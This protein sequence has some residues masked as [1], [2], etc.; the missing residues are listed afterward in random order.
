M[1]DNLQLA[2]EM[3]FQ[4]SDQ[5]SSDH[6][7]AK[8]FLLLADIYITKENNFQAKAT[9]ESIIEHHDGEDLVN[10]ARKKWEEIIEDEIAEKQVLE[11]QS[12][13][14]IL[15]YEVDYEIEFDVDTTPVIDK[16]YEVQIS[17]SLNI[18]MDSLEMIK[19]NI[20]D[21]ETE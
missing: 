10:V 21:Y 11:E 5:Y 4:L 19:K 12:Y 1:D 8:S 16:D 3:I 20:A 17:D 2:E 14:Q 18:Q 9:L 7:I 13:I 6:F 15:D